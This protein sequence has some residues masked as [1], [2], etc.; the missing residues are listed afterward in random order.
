MEELAQEKW[1]EISF[2]ENLNTNK[3]GVRVVAFVGWALTLSTAGTNYGT[4][5]SAFCYNKT[6]RKCFQLTKSTKLIRKINTTYRICSLQMDTIKS[7]AAIPKRSLK[8][9]KATGA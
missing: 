2:I 8:Y 5:C 7:S 1:T 9:L 3:D 6:F 4:Q